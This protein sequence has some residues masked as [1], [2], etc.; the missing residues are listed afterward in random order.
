VNQFVSW[1]QHPWLPATGRLFGPG[2]VAVVLAAVMAAAT[3]SEASAQDRTRMWKLT[4]SGKVGALAV[5]VAKSETIRFDKTVGD[6]VVGSSEIVDVIPMT[7]RSVYVLGKKIGTTNLTLFDENKDFIGVI[8]LV[9][10]YDIESLQLKLR[11]VMP[12]EWITVRDL[13]GRVMLSG[14]LADSVAVTKAL[15]VAEQYA[16]AAV[17][18][19]LT[20][21]SPQQVMLEVR[22]VEAT[23]SAG[24]ELGLDVSAV[25]HGVVAE[26]GLGL[27]TGS[28]PFGAIL[29]R[30][31][32]SGNNEI[33]VLLRALERNGTVRTL[34]EPNLVALSG[35][36]ASFLAGGEFPFPV[37]QENNKITIEFK[38][39]G[40]G[41]VFT[42]TVLAE[43]LINVKIEPEVSQL[44]TTRTLK[45]ND[46]EIPSLTVRR[47]STTV[48][49]RDGQS[50]AIAGLLQ[51]SNAKTLS[52]LPWIGDVPVLG[53][54]FRSASFQR[55]ETDLVIIVTP[56]LVRPAD[57]P[58]KLVTPLDDRL[59]GND[60]DF[61]L[62]GKAE[63]PKSV[64]EIMTSPD[65]GRATI[66]HIVK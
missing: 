60:A 63:I 15:A 39:F 30:L 7:N 45:F 36:K 35:D 18:N 32:G 42:P 54:L 51:T 44:D 2:M 5:T 12:H 65:H 33:D 19:A 25:T 62:E 61:F 9:V 57:A 66:G 29:T 34:A 8:D 10:S 21:R 3:L 22:F 27:A 14:N 26:T 43:R 56:R 38:K 46:V 13:N 28:L 49:L 1:V 48:E 20:V 64:L 16:P 52:Q 31:L 24:R 23:R 53:A 6:V 17:T 58:A 37:A 55:N 40:V 47:A 11:E 59:P 4:G 41:L 50:F